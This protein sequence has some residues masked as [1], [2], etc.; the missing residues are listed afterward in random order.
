MWLL[1]GLIAVPLIEIALFIRLGGWIGLWPTIGFVVLTAVIGTYM[2][3]SQ[4]VSTLRKL[5]GALDRGEDPTAQ[6]GQGALILFAGALLLTPGFFTDAVGFAL[7][8]EGVRL[9]LI[10]WLGPRLARR[11]VRSASR[12]G[13]SG[14]AG[15]F[16]AEGRSQGR[17][18]EDAAIDVEYHDVTDSSDRSDR[19]R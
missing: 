11:V 3:R 13:P 4:G 1:V 14:F 18:N 12:P 8:N 15:G 7:L 5:Q 17:G 10:A 6:L 2:L 9:R 19:D 16:P